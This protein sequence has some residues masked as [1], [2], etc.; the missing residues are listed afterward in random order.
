VR[1]VD[2]RSLGT[3]LR[4]EICAPNGLDFHIGLTD[5]ELRRVADL[6]GYGEAFR[7]SQDDWTDL[8]RRGLTNP[9]GAID[10]AVVNGERWRRAEIPAV[11]GHG[12]RRAWRACTSPS[13]RAGSCR[14]DARD[15]DVGR[16]FGHRPGDGR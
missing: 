8:L 15:R 13:T 14:R 2:G 16:R 4:E 5:A 12:R 9:P 11:N 7:A 6:T 10:P 3:F 1:R